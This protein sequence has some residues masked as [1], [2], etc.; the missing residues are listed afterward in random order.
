MEDASHRCVTQ[1]ASSSS[2]GPGS[3]RRRASLRSPAGSGPACSCASRRSRRWTRSRR[4]SGPAGVPSAAPCRW[5]EPSGLIHR[6]RR[7]GDRRDYWS[8]TP[9]AMVRVIENRQRQI[10]PV[11]RHARSRHRGPVGSP[12][13]DAGAPPGRPRALPGLVRPSSSTRSNGTRSTARSAPPASLRERIEMTA[14][15]RTE[16]LTKSYG[17]HRGHRRRRPARS[18]TGEVFGFLGPNGAGK[19]TTIRTLLDLIRPTSGP[20]VRVRHRDDRRPGRR[21]IAAIGYI[22]GEFALYD[23]L[24]GGQTI[25]VLR[26]PPRRRRRGV[27]ARR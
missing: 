1:S 10:R 15:I 13:G 21:S 27:P 18:T 4:R 14:I 17:A 19:T 12:A 24:T 3:W 9:D 23:R 2:A 26:E 5:L 6:G 11:A 8:T 25:A 22:P 7:R 16:R 20:R